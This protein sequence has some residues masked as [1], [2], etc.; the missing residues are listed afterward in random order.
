M[1]EASFVWR[2]PDY[3]C[4]SVTATTMG[5]DWVGLQV[6][7]KRRTGTQAINDKLRPWRP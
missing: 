4:V 6:V 5:A 2:W 7:A 3:D 1:P